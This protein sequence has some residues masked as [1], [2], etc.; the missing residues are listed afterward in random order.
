MK[1]L[2]FLY[3]PVAGFIIIVINTISLEYGR[4]QA[5]LGFLVM[6]IAFSMIFVAIRQYREDTLGG[7]ISFRTAFQI[8]LGISVVAGIVYV[9]IWELYLAINDYRFIE[10]YSS[11]MVEAK[12]LDGAS[13]AEL[14]KA[15]ADAMQFREQYSN[16]MFRVPMTFLEVFP[17]GLLVS[18]AGAAFLR[19]H[20]GAGSS[21][22]RS[23]S[24]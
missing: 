18:L 14:T 2:I 17:P 15:T 4:G 19:N 1:R 12:R 5:W 11:A 10:T 8:G 6:F 16:P 7:V 22:S 23:K 21:K 24:Q 3:G 9:A 13:D 20:P